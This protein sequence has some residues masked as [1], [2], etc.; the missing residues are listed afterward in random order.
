MPEEF[1]EQE[2]QETQEREVV[3][4]EVETEEQRVPVHVVKELRDELRQAR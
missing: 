1:E 4:T 3:E 2:I